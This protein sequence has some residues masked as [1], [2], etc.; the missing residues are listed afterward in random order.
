MHSPP[1][2]QPAPP[3]LLNKGGNEQRGG[4]RREGGT[5]PADGRRRLPKV[6]VTNG[7]MITPAHPYP[8]FI[9]YRG[10]LVTLC[11]ALRAQGAAVAAPSHPSVCVGRF[12][13]R[14]IHT[15][16]AGSHTV[17]SPPVRRRALR[18]IIQYPPTHSVYIKKPAPPLY[19][20]GAL[21]L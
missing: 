5:R 1:P 10:A 2:H 18:N 17:L 13:P 11:A 16:P 9:M 20:G 4:Q 21:L 8:P 3:S 6:E 15:P 19:R 14:I 12:G 7:W